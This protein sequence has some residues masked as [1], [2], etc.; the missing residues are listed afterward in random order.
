[1]PG[2]GQACGHDGTAGNDG[3]TDDE[4]AAVHV[5]I[6][7]AQFFCNPGILTVFFVNNF[8]LNYNQGHFGASNAILE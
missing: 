2:F 3:G 7:D 5:V 8:E 1:M 4:H 6:C